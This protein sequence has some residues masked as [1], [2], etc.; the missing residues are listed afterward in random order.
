MIERGPRISG[1]LLVV[2]LAVTLLLPTLSFNFSFLPTQAASGDTSDSPIIITTPAELDGIRNG[3]NKH[4]KLGK[5]IDLTDYLAPSGNG[6]NEGDGWEPIG[7][8]SN[9]FTGSLDGDGYVITGLWINRP[10]TDN[11]GLFGRTQSA[12]IKNL[13]VILASNG[14]I[15]NYHVGGLVGLQ[16]AG[17]GDSS[18]IT[19][20]YAT[21][22]IMAVRY[23]GGL[24]GVQRTNIGSSAITNCYATGNVTATTNVGGLMGFQVADSGG[25]SS[26]TNCY[27]T[28]SATA[29]AG[30][31]GG[32][33][34]HQIAAY[35][36]TNSIANCYATGDVAATAYA[37]GLVGFQEIGSGSTNSIANCFATGDVMAEECAGGLVGIRYSGGS[38]S[39]C[40]ITN[41][42]YYDRALVTA[43]GT[44]VDM[45]GITTS[46]IHGIAISA[47]DLMDK[48]T[49]TSNNW[50]F[51]DSSPATSPWY[52]DTSDP[53]YPFPKLNMGNESFPFLF[54]IINEGTN[55]TVTYEGNDLDVSAL[56]FTLD[57]KA[58]T[59]TYSIVSGAGTTGEGSIN[60][61]TGM[62]T[63]TKAG[64][65]TIALNT[66]NVPYYRPAAEVTAVLTVSKRAGALVNS[67]TI[68]MLTL[69]T[70]YISTTLE[71]SPAT[72]QNIEY[73]ISTTN[74]PPASWQESPIFTGLNT[75]TNYYFFARSA[76][77][78]LYSAGP[79][80][81]SG[82]YKILC[83]LIYN[84]NGHTSGTAPN[85]GIYTNG[86]LVVT[87]GNVGDLA[88]TGYKF[89]G[90]STDPKATVAH[91][92][93]NFTFS[94]T[95]NITLYAVWEALPVTYTVTYNGNGNTGGSAPVDS[96]SPY[97]AVSPVIVMGQG[98]LVRTGYTFL[99]WANS[100]SA[101]SPTYGATFVINSDTTLY[102]VWKE[103]VVENAY[104]GYL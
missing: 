103:S 75:T 8:Y 18:S 102:A 104:N 83:L 17:I 2:L 44:P 89:I 96:N 9:P 15:G 53:G 91:Y 87:S 82:P 30:H 93:V 54:R 43:N 81:A 19:N 64:T 35:G 12:T 14:I 98:T 70:I 1:Q 90:W 76:E 26:I 22:N 41:C 33:V 36:G 84:G 7:T 51:N 49:Y 23:A 100:S 57:P 21:G 60:S 94:I 71:N 52:W 68:T 40:T 73:G 38:G 37:G 39:T 56:L 86:W 95:S 92:P 29:T 46:N 32:L 3:L 20:C 88:K 63:V 62:L 5:N 61:I 25:I 66:A 74:T 69:D 31:A 28:S 77:N 58:D 13:G 72:G 80:S 50:L 79:P 97:N 27:A 47:S 99:G 65:F 4:Y 24:V 48:A 10:T 16:E 55:N 6:H 67:I 101:A 11:V 85:A 78:I 42:Y 59:P 45:D 34:G